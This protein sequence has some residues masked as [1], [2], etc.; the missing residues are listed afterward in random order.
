MGESSGAAGA[1]VSGSEAADASELDAAWLAVGAAPA[2]SPPGSLEHPA[3][4]TKI[5]NAAPR[6]APIERVIRWVTTTG[7]NL[8]PSRYQASTICAEYLSDVWSRSLV[9]V[10]VGSV[11]GTVV[12]ASITHRRST[13]LRT[14]CGSSWMSRCVPTL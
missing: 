1:A 12:M 13:V 3:A 8:F 2:R 11:S 10:E 5:A 14:V 9:M 6:A 7:K 4:A